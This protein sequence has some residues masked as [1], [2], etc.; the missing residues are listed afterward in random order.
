MQ[1]A[2]PAYDLDFDVIGLP[3]S[4]MF[5]EAAGVITGV[6]TVDDASASPF[7]IEISTIDGSGPI[8]AQLRLAVEDP[9]DGIFFGSFDAFCNPQ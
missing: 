5:D 2:F 7:D 9:V 4:L 1:D 8:T 3:P 6:P